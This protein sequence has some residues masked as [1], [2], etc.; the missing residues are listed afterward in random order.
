MDL[1]GPCYSMRTATSATR[2]APTALARHVFQPPPQTTQAKRAG[3]GSDGPT[4][5][6]IDPDSYAVQPL[7]MPRRR[8]ISLARS[9][10]TGVA[11]AVP[12]GLALTEFVKRGP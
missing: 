9:G 5:R 2:S 6:L 12:C 10:R 1:Q 4:D 7:D 11:P 3:V 8:P